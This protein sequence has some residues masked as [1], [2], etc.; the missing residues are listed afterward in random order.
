MLLN[1]S[2]TVLLLLWHC[3]CK[4]FGDIPSHIPANLLHIPITQEEIYCT[5]YSNVILLLEWFLSFLW[6]DVW[7][8]S[9]TE[10]NFVDSGDR[11]WYLGNTVWRNKP[12]FQAIM[13]E[14][15]VGQSVPRWR[16][17]TIR[18]VLPK[19]PMFLPGPTSQADRSQVLPYRLS[20]CQHRP[21]LGRGFGD[22][23]KQ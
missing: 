18:T 9:T 15:E 4:S 21:G 3:L 14:S 11:L 17:S 5:I 23:S 1:S 2:A 22:D 12:Q 10:S 19:M 13:T 7:Q 6:I 20:K 8:T 16:Q